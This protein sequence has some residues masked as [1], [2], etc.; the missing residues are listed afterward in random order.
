MFCQETL[1]SVRVDIIRSDD[2]SR[3]RAS[4]RGIR[5]WLDT[6]HALKRKR[7]AKYCLRRERGGSKHSTCMAFLG[8]H[9]E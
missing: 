6:E 5:G 3:E 9:H 4:S 7:S 8:F 2:T 1:K